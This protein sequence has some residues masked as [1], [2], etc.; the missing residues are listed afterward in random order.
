M[1]DLKTLALSMVILVITVSIGIKIAATT[2]DTFTNT[3]S[4]EYINADAGVTALG[5]YSD[6]YAIIIITGVGSA[7][8]G[9]LGLFNNRQ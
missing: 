6:W 4:Q 7:V 5:D 8:I 2:R 3:S 1:V 9:M